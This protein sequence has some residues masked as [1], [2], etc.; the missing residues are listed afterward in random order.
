MAHEP[1]TL[2]ASYERGRADFLE[3]LHVEAGL[4]R[5]TLASYSSDLGRFLSWAAAR[6]A[7]EWSQI[8]RELLLDYLA[9]RRAEGAAEATVARNLSA[10]RM[11]LRYLV[12]EGRLDNDPA[13]LIR[14]PMLRRALPHALDVEQVE[15]LLAAPERSV[16]RSARAGGGAF[17]GIAQRD[18]ALLMV[19]YSCGARVSEAI[20]LRTDGLEPSLRVMRLAGKGGK[21][22]LVP[23]GERA[24]Q[25]LERWLGDG[26]SRIRESRKRPEVFLTHSGAPLDRTNAWRRVK[27]AALS[28]GLDPSIS[29][30]TLRHCFATHMIEGGADLRSVQEMLGHASIRTTEVYTHLDSEHILSL[31]RL[32]HPR[33]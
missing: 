12:A 26:R 10:A 33:G 17:D 3:A 32:Y 4:A 25:A 29:P 21:Q 13:A 22:R 14:A 24:R 31:H 15:S 16:R 5:A 19:L 1:V 27:R 18:S 8:D 23:C 7:V 9:A 28:A 11:L 6:G 20:G 2:P 30:H